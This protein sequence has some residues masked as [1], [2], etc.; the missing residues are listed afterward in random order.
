MNQQNETIICHSKDIQILISLHFSFLNQLFHAHTKRFRIIKFR[1]KEDNKE[2]TSRV[3]KI[4]SIKIS[5][6]FHVLEKLHFEGREKLF[7]FHRSLENI[8]LQ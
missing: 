4:S 5:R 8:T 1:L 3:W 6:S 7:S 2:Y